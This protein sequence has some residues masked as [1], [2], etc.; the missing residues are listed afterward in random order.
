MRHIIFVGLPWTYASFTQ[1]RGRG[2]RK[3]AHLHLAKEK[4]NVTI[5]TLKISGEFT[6]KDGV[7]KRS[8]DEEMMATIQAKRKLTEEVHKALRGK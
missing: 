2:A 4:R 8:P 1:V 6:T 5:H 3:A 7:K